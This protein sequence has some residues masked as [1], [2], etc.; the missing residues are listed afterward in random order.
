M[1]VAKYQ[2]IIG[3]RVRLA[4]FAIAKAAGKMIH[5]AVSNTASVLRTGSER[6]V[7]ITGTNITNRNTIEIMSPSAHQAF[8]ASNASDRSHPRC[9]QI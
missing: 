4:T 8:E 9:G 1:I 2:I 3:T 7:N 5:N 6:R